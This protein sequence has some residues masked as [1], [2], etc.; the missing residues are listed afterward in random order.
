MPNNNEFALLTEAELNELGNV[1]ARGL[2]MRKDFE[3]FDRWRTVWGTK[4]GLGLIR[5]LDNMLNGIKMG[6]ITV[7]H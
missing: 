2:G 1:L 4:T 6:D 3:H 5:M 7:L